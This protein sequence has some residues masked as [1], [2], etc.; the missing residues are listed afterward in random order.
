MFLLFPTIRVL[1]QQ[2]TQVNFVWVSFG[3]TIP[4]C[5][6]RSIMINQFFTCWGRRKEVPG[7]HIHLRRVID[8]I[9]E[10]VRR[11]GDD[12]LRLGPRPRSWQL[13]P[14]VVSFFRFF[15]SLL[16]LQEVNIAMEN[17]IGEIF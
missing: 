4:G 3:P 10:L 5:I 8:L 17:S 15:F 14:R 13:G 16:K 12:A 6:S 11:P 2:S 7:S 1:V 9:A